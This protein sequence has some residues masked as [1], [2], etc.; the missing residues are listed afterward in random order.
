MI[1]WLV[2]NALRENN[3]IKKLLIDIFSDWVI[4]VSRRMTNI[5]SYILYIMSRIS[6][7]QWDDDDVY[8]VLD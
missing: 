2:F 1:D 7:I 4:V 8:F 6:Y 5:L 3:K